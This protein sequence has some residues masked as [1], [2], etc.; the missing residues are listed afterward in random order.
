[1]PAGIGVQRAVSYAKPPCSPPSLA[2]GPRSCTPASRGH[3]DMVL[4]VL[5]G[6]QDPDGG[7]GL[8]LPP[9]PARALLS[10]GGLDIEPESWIPGPALTT[11]TWVLVLSRL[12]TAQGRTH[13]CR[14][15]CWLE[16]TKGSLVP[17]VRCAQEW[18]EAEGMS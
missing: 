4:A 5:R 3:G 7:H 10:H 12:T 1:M 13:G 16:G 6:R 14:G 8:S 15:A 17:W 18:R 2:G 11:E 9:P